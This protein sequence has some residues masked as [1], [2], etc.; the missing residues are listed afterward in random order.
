MKAI[1]LFSYYIYM[2]HISYPVYGLLKELRSLTRPEHKHQP[3]LSH[4]QGPILLS[5]QDKHVLSFSDEVEMQ[6]ES[7]T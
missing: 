3:M 1:I 5:P 2:P 6:W 4:M 7:I